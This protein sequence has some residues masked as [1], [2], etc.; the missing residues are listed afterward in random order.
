MEGIIQCATAS[1]NKIRLGL[2]V[3][4]EFCAIININPL[5]HSKLSTVHYG[6][7][8]NIKQIWLVKKDFWLV[9]GA[10]DWPINLVTNHLSDTVILL[11]SFTFKTV[12]HTSTGE[13]NNFLFQVTVQ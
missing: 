7:F 13:I 12:F 6:S 9:N 1:K 8:A 11:L 5:Q 2:F 3:Q 4:E 10:S